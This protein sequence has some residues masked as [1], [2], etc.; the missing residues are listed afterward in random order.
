MHLE[1]IVKKFKVCLEKLKNSN[2]ELRPKK[3]KSN[4]IFKNTYFLRARKDQREDDSLI[5]KASECEGKY[6]IHILIDSFNNYLS[7]IVPGTILGA[8]DP[9]KGQNSQS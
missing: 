2:H 1:R 7:S 4:K 5:L 6:L 9:A 8:D 3:V